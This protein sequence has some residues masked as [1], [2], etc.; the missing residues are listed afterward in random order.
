MP[1]SPFHA[2]YKAMNLSN[3][4]FVDKTL[5]PSFASSDIEIY[6]YQIAAAKFPLCS[7]YLKGAI[8]CD[9]GSLGKTYEAM[10]VV[11]Q[12]WYEGKQ[13]IL[14][15]VPIPLLYQWTQVIENRFSIPYFCIDNNIVFDDCLKNG[16]ENPFL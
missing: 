8:L 2:F 11:T 13:N 7:S 16:D 6:P 12:M 3:Y 5:I 10:L 1:I 4:A 14:I 9:E 15:V